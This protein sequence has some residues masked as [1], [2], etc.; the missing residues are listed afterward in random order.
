MSISFDVPGHEADGFNVSN[1]NGMSIL[2][3]LGVDLE[4]VGT[5]DPADLKGRCLEALVFADDQGFP[6][7]EDRY[8]GHATVIDCGRPAGYLADKFNRLLA[9][10]DQAAALGQQVRWA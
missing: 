7:V 3:A 8:P 10:A 2:A 4:Y 9:L 1:A 6:T 5:I